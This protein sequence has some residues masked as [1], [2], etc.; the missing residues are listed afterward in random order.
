VAEMTAAVPRMRWGVGRIGLGVGAGLGLALVSFANGGYFPTAWAWGALIALT[1]IA[2]FLVLGNA[3]RPSS[4]SLVSLGGLTAFAVWTWLALLW[5]DVASATV[6]EG[7]RM[8]LYVSVLAALVLIV[9]RSTVPI[10]LWASFVAVFFASGYG[11]LTR[12]FP[13]RLGVV[14][15]IAGGRL[16]EP[17]TYCNALGVF[18]AMGMLLGFGFAARAHNVTARAAAGATLPLLNVTV[19]FT[20]SRGAWIAAGLGLVFAIAVDPRRLQFVLAALLLAPVSAVAVFVA[21]REEALSRTDAPISAASHDGHRLALYLVVFAAASGLVALCLAHAQRRVAPP[22]LA[23]LAFGGLVA[24]TAVAC[25]LALFVRYGGPVT[26]ARKGYDAFTTASGPDPVNLNEHLISFTGSQRPPVWHEAWRDYRANPVL[27]SGPG[28]FEQYWNKHRPIHKKL[29]DAHSLYLEVL[30]ELGPVGLLLL[31]V[32]LGTPLAA[33]FLAR[34]HPLVPGVLAAYV[35]YLAHAGIDWDWE[36]GALTLLALACAAALLT[37]AERGDRARWALSPGARFGSLAVVLLLLVPAVVGLAGASALEASDG[38]LTKGR[39]GEAASQ[40]RKAARWWRWSPEPWRQLGETQA[41]QGDFAAAQRSYRKAISKD[42]RDWMLWYDLSSVTSG[43][44]SAN[45]LREVS[46]LNPFY[47][48]DL[49]GTN[50][51]SR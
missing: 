45:A 36:M 10:L 24:L 8:L 30:A 34:G 50:D 11:L 3:V 13:E 51:V 21:S 39:Y 28:T 12:L 41:E 44:A 9:R 22:R 31:A 19:Y 29:R 2:A 4:L 5:S 35:A 33:A 1:V 49:D 16:A 47:E 7:L 23:R 26:I 40:A 6:L 46:R 14:D 43:R 27:G 37:A 15:P 17:L 20:F 48:S 18:A 32:A 38:A 42:G 25:L